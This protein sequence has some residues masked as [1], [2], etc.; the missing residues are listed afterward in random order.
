MA[1]L[2]I[3]EFF[4][5]DGWPRWVMDQID[6]EEGIEGG[7]RERKEVHVRQNPTETCQNDQEQA[8]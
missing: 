6:N 3:S 8:L 4:E 2:C 7:T 1:L 5:I